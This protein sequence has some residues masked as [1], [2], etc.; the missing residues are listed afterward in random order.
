MYKVCSGST[1]VMDPSENLLIIDPVLELAQNEAGSFSFS[2]PLEH[3]AYSVLHHTDPVSVFKEGEGIFYGRITNIESDFYGT[4]TIQAEGELA[5]LSD[6]IQRPAEYHDL[7][8]RGFIQTLLDQHNEQSDLKFELGVVN[9]TDPNDSLYRFTNY[10][11][12]LF[13]LM[14]KVVNRLGGIISIRHEEDKRILDILDDY[15]RMNTQVIRFKENLMDYVTNSD[16]LD[17]A[18]VV[19]PLGAVKETRSIEALEERV[20]IKDVNGQKDYLESSDG[21]DKYGRICKVVTFDD[22]NTPSL[23]KSRGQQWLDHNQYASL[24]IEVSAVDLSLLHTQIMDFR[25]LDKIRV[26]SDFHQIDEYYP[27]TSVRICLLQPDQNLYHLGGTIQS[28]TSTQKNAQVAL[29]K[30]MES[31]RLPNDLVAEAREQ[32]SQLL[33]S[34][35][36]YG[37]VV[38]VQNDEGQ[39]QEI[40][41]IDTQ[42]LETAQKIWRWNMG[43]LAFSASGYAGPYKTAMT[44]D[45]TIS[46]EMIAANSIVAEKIDV[47]YRSSVE[48]QITDCLDAAKE[49]TT[50]RLR[51]YW[52]QVETETAIQNSADSI[53]LSVIQSAQDYVDDQFTTKLAQYYTKSEVDVLRD[54]ITLKVYQEAALPAN[55]L[56]YTSDWGS[57]YSWSRHSSCTVSQDYIGGGKML[58]Y[59][60][61][62]TGDAQILEGKSL[63]VI[64][65]TDCFYTFSGYI[66]ADS[67]A[68]ITLKLKAGKKLQG[69]V[70]NHFSSCCTISSDPENGIITLNLR[71]PNYQFMFAITFRVSSESAPDTFG[72]T[73]TR[74]GLTN[75]NNTISFSRFKLEKGRSPTDYQRKIGEAA[76]SLASLQVS[77]DSIVSTVATKVGTTQIASYIQ[78]NAEAVRIAWSNISNYIEFSGGSL[79]IFSASTKTAAYRLIQLNQN[80]MTFWRDSYNLGRIGVNSFSGEPGARGLVFDLE[81]QGSYMAWASMP[82]ST[83]DGYIIRMMYC[84]RPFDSYLRDHMYFSSYVDFMQD[85]D[86]HN[87]SLNNAQLNQPSIVNKSGYAGFGSWDSPTYVKLPSSINSDG[88]VQDWYNCTIAGGVIY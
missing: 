84:N 25:L 34:F 21:V 80:G 5:Y 65:V 87:Y 17:L 48:K 44:M 86:F 51:S 36:K 3:P 88:T 62:N 50:E 41:I 45:G 81:Y 58:E 72:L 29:T 39:I 14:D 18:T 6:S 43:G 8:V 63:G 54:S 53:T 12:T 38:Q 60:D 27:L 71:P 10:E 24:Q 85:V 26:Q 59:R 16:I 37:H 73:I 9:I 82:N 22:I 70:T 19:I 75:S 31:I 35:G 40:C 42:D 83:S 20:S 74:T 47:S 52:T 23:L 69:T 13:C 64:L 30:K 57:T 77:Y 11:N 49:D 76:S 28:Y 68:L 67:S 79:N 46:G 78:Q 33:N 56:P 61:A 66:K 2:L 55:L 4:K 1:L 7:S 15:P 32:V